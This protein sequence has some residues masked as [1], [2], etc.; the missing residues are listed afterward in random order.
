MNSHTILLHL[1]L[2]E[3]VG[4]AAVQTIYKKLQENTNKRSAD[5]YAFRQSNWQRMGFSIP[6]AE[7][8]VAG[9][10]DIKMLEDELE[11]IEKHKINWVTIADDSYPSL[12]RHIHLPPPILYW[13]GKL[14]DEKNIAIVGSRKTNDYGKNVIDSLVP[15]L[16]NQDFSIVSGG[17]IGADTMAHQAAVAHNGK[18]IVILGSG[19]LKP[20]PHAN[21]KLFEK[22]IEMGGA[23]VSSFGL[24]TAPYPG[25]FP[26][27]NRIISGISKGVVVIQAAKKSGARITA[28][29]AMEQGRDVFAI[30]GALDDP[31]SEGCHALIKE[32]AKI[33]VN[34]GDILEEYGI[35]NIISSPLKKNEPKKI[36]V[37]KKINRDPFH[38]K[39]IERCRHSHAIDDLASHFSIELHLLQG[40][41]FELQMGGEVEQD[42]M[43]LW[44]TV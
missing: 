42:F 41:L 14:S 8:I 33:T 30:P 39:I 6:T 19:L 26:A 37:V 35:K 34:A 31:F 27:R 25:N 32:G 43:G 38:Q 29:C 7:K 16:V 5:L 44:K 2:I 23:V 40:I 1:S 3:G 11:L 20:Y 9:L 22:V 18:T 21:K 24:K 4:A 13:H 10:A 17:A 12:L 36:E 15:E 28:D